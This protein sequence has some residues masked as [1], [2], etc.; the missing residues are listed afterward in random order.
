MRPAASIV[1]PSPH[2]SANCRSLVSEPS[3]WTSNATRPPLLPPPPRPP[4]GA[5]AAPAGGAAAR[6]AADA[7]GD[8]QRLLIRAEDDSVPAN[9]P[10]PSHDLAL[11]VGVVDAAHRHVHA[12]LAVC[13]HVVDDAGDAIERLA[14]VLVRE[15]FALRLQRPDGVAQR[16]LADKDLTLRVRGDRSARV[17]VRVDD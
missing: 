7:A 4:P 14:L 8:V 9:G 10:E 17:R 15:E 3:G 11:G 1:L 2:V 16:A 6:V 12:A 13:R 5:A